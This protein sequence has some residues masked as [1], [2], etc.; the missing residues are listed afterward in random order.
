MIGNSHEP[1]IMPSWR[2]TPP[3]T[4]NPWW[5]LMRRWQHST[6]GQS[7]TSNSNIKLVA[8]FFGSRPAI[9]YL[10]LK[11]W[12]ANYSRMMNDVQIFFDNNNIMMI[13][14][15]GSSCIL[16]CQYVMLWRCL[17]LIHECMIVFM[18][19]VFTFNGYVCTY[20]SILHSRRAQNSARRR[21]TKEQLV[22]YIHG[23]HPYT[24]EASERA[25][26]LWHCSNTRHHGRNQQQTTARDQTTNNITSTRVVLSNIEQQNV[27]IQLTQ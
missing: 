12:N 20:S 21:G 26:N 4:G 23:I 24:A 27:L 19:I 10:L 11:Q 1:E 13:F 7:D 22:S 18:D 3:A 8:A 15:I 14:I 17:R 25:L 2:P 9:Q 16:F 5:R 6:R